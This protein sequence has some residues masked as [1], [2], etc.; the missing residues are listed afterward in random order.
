M[1]AQRPNPRPYPMG[2]LLRAALRGLIRASWPLSAGPKIPGIVDRVEHQ[3]RMLMV[4]MSPW[5]AKGLCVVFLLLNYSQVW[6]LKGLRPLHAL[7][8]ERAV[9]ALKGL[10]HVRVLALRQ[11]IIAIRATIITAYY[12]QPEV[13]FAL[14]Y[15]PHPWVR[16]RLALRRRLMAGEQARPEDSVPFHPER[17][18]L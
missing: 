10:C 18:G 16:E 12:D 11:L 17:V 1:K 8:R 4:Y 13:H 5:S 9:A 6:L 14:G 15:H 7:K 3:V 2:G